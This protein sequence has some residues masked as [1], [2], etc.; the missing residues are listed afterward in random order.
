MCYVYN[1]WYDISCAILYVTYNTLSK[2]EYRSTTTS[3]SVCC[4]WW[5]EYFPDD[6]PAN[7]SPLCASHKERQYTFFQ[8]CFYASFLCHVLRSTLNIGFR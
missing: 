3:R 4:L 2:A 1:Q 8:K 6:F 7:S 5:S